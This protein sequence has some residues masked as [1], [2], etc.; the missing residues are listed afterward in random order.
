M[1]REIRWFI[2]TFL[3]FH[4]L[5]SLCCIGISE[6]RAVTNLHGKKNDP[7][8]FS[9]FQNRAGGYSDSGRRTVALTE[10][11]SQQQKTGP[12]GPKLNFKCYPMKGNYQNVPSGSFKPHQKR[13]S[14]VFRYPGGGGNGPGSG[15]VSFQVDL[16]ALRRMVEIR[17][18]QKKLSADQ[19]SSRAR[20]LGKLI[21]MG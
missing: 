21:G 15:P 20:V 9:N 3:L 11:S 18:L 17:K 4:V 10:L 5:T 2:L 12:S 8:S 14:V 7:G 1:F 19:P 16:V 13:S 6:A